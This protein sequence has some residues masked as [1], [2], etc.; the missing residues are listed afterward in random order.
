MTQSVL[1][2]C[3]G[4]ICRSPIGEAAVKAAA[5]RAGLE[6]VVD[7]AGVAADVGW[8]PERHAI[9]AAAEAGLE[10]GGRARQVTPSDLE[11]F[12]VVVAMD[13]WVAERLRHLAPG[14]EGDRVQMFRSFD[15]AADSIEVPDPYGAPIETYR[16]VV[17]MILPAAAGLVEQLSQTATSGSR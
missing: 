9:E 6:L 5:I 7:S 10:V 2:V 8:P 1:V 11:R 4:N 13:S 3:A 17:E 12:D 14:L 15:P 16:R